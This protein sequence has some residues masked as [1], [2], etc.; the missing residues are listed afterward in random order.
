MK[1]LLC[2]SFK[3]QDYLQL[4]NM[5][6]SQAKAMFKFRVRMAP[7]GENFRGGQE[8]VACPLCRLHPD[9]QEESFSCVK[10]KQLIDV[11]GNYKD[12]FGWTF[13]SELVKTVYNIYT[14]REE[15]RKLG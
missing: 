1:N 12:I 5:N 4:K 6:P 13:S 3:M 15:Y 10:V 11:Q 8:T 2:T 7:F 14:F 9:G